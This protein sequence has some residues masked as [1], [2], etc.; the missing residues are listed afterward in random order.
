MEIRMNFRKHIC[1]ILVGILLIVQLSSCSLE[2]EI[3]GTWY[4]IDTDGDVTLEIFDETAVYHNNGRWD[5]YY[6]EWTLDENNLVLN[7][8]GH[9]LYYQV[10]DDPDYGQVLYDPEEEEIVACHE[11]E[12]AQIL[13]NEILEEE[14]RERQEDL[15]RFQEIYDEVQKALIGTWK[16]EKEAS[17]M[18]TPYIYEKETYVFEADGTYSY[19]KDSRYNGTQEFD[20]KEELHGTYEIVC[21]EGGEEYEYDGGYPEPEDVYLAIKF[22]DTSYTQNKYMAINIKL[23]KEGHLTEGQDEELMGWFTVYEKAE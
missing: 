4:I 21:Y 6:I 14:E 13:I 5:D 2:S 1:L 9:S 20:R 16:N 17:Y 22:S 11:Q 18:R 23:L 15:Q 12:K 8:E 7:A 19:T 10:L 3:K